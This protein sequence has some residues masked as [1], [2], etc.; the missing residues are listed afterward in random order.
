MGKNRK[1]S[2]GKG[3]PKGQRFGGRQLHGSSRSAYFA[4]APFRIAANKA[5]R[6]VREAARQA[7]GK[8]KGVV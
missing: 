8:G 1:K 7:G 6:I 5:R 2:Q 3:S 4:I